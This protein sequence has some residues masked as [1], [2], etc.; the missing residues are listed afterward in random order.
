MKKYAQSMSEI[1]SRL[2]ATNPRDQALINWLN[3]SDSADGP[4]FRWA[5]FKDYDRDGKIEFFNTF[6]P[7]SPEY[8]EWELTQGF[9]NRVQ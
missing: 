6:L 9:L 8:A 3:D 1:A 5:H 7:S 2:E 4:W